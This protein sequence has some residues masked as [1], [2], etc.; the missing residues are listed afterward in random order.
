MSTPVA[1]CQGRQQSSPTSER[2]VVNQLAE[3]ERRNRN[4]DD[5]LMGGESEAA[6]SS[7][8]LE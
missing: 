5:G 2:V 6:W 7:G 8:H 4:K 3:A 1:A